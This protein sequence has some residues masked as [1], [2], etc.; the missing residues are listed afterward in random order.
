MQRLLDIYL[1]RRY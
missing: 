1:K